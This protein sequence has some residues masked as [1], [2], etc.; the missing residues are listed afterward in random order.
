MTDDVCVVYFGDTA[1][2]KGSVGYRILTALL[3]PGF[4]H[5]GV[6]VKLDGLVWV[7][8][9]MSGNGHDLILVEETSPYGV[10]AVLSRLG[11]KTMVVT[12]LRPQ[13]RARAW[14]AATCVDHVKRVIGLYAPTVVTPWDLYRRLKRENACR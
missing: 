1:I 5:C 8:S 14:G 7:T 10:C 3:K 6:A 12:P 9:E 11:V 13:N 4:R 2:P